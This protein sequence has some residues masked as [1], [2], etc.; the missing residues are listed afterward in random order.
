[1]ISL[2]EIPEVRYLTW[3][4]EFFG[5]E[6]AEILPRQLN[7]PALRATLESLWSTG[8]GLVYWA[9]DPDDPES[10]EAAAVCEGLKVDTKIT[11]GMNADVMSK[12][13][14][15]AHVIREYDAWLECDGYLEAIAIDCGASSRFRFDP[16]ISDERCSEMYRQWIRNSVNR[17]FADS[18][19]VSRN[20]G[21]ISGLVTVVD[22]SGTGSIGLL[23][24]GQKFRGQGIGRAL[25][26]AALTWFLTHGCSKASVV[27]QA[28]NHAACRLYESAGFSPKRT[29]HFYHFWSAAHDSV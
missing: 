7:A 25:V 23:G 8:V 16:G 2:S 26:G 13:I 22:Q 5:V 4:S 10:A 11:Y 6:T 1:M 28:R 17:T 21:E 9:A 18:V 29:D 3:D 24:V 12:E 27:T 19:L 15:S 14:P 20:Q